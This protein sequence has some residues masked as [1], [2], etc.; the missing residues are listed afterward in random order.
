MSEQ[1]QVKC[2]PFKEGTS[3]TEDRLVSDVSE[4]PYSL[5]MFAE[6]GKSVA[7]RSGALVVSEGSSTMD[8]IRGV[9]V[10]GFVAFAHSMS[11]S[12]CSQ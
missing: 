7:T 6:A 10:V 3:L 9:Q 8:A 5:V 12:I 4:V 1:S 11:C 2:F